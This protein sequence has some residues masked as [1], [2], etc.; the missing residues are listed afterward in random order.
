MM[1]DEQEESC[2]EKSKEGEKTE[3]YKVEAS[4]IFHCIL[5]NNLTKMYIRNCLKAAVCELLERFCANKQKK[6]KRRTK[7]RQDKRKA[8]M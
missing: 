7:M 8:C 5:G 2:F 6:Y 3:R 1:T 4:I